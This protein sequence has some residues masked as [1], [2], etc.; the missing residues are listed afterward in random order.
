[1]KKLRH[2]HG[3]T[4]R[5]VRRSALRHVHPLGALRPARPPRMGQAQR[6]HR[7]R[8]V[9]PLFRPLRPR[10][11]R[12]ARM[13][14]RREGRRDEVRGADG[15]APRGLLPVGLRLHGLQGP[16]DARR[17]GGAR[18]A[19]R[20][21]GRLPRR[22]PARRLLLLA[23]GLAPP[24]FHD[25]PPPPAAQPPAR[26]NRPPQRRP[27]HEALRQVH[28][29]PGGGAAHELRTHRHHVVR[30]LLPRSR[31]TRRAARKGARRLGE[32][33]ARR[34]R[35]FAPA[36]RAGGQQARPAGRRRLPHARTVAIRISRTAR[37]RLRGAL[38]RV[39][40]VFR[41]VGLPPRRGVVEERQAVRGNARPPRV[42]RRQPDHERRAH[43]A[44]ALRLPREG[45]PRRL[46]GVD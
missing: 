4:D 43:G 45:A 16:R 32:R 27:R 18:P 37:G 36:A 46:R 20:V 12:S 7:G 39:P 3:Y 26:G 6:V 2:R 44:R 5:M 24:R 17:G 1:M 34:T 9:R 42:A 33:K 31:Q 35:A 22:G 11:L 23:A 13:G 19:A 14:A 15:Q 29:R 38:G 25:R 21:R 8:S 30:L 28:A 10:P 41:L 40:D